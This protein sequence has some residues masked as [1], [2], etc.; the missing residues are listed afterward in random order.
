VFICKVSFYIILKKKLFENNISKH[1]F[2]T[3]K[4]TFLLK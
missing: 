1:I 3:D 2:G 4:N